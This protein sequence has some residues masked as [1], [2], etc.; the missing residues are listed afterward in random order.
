MPGSDGPRV[1]S[2]QQRIKASA[3]HSNMRTYHG[4]V[5]EYPQKVLGIFSCQLGQSTT[6]VDESN[7]CFGVSCHRHGK[8]PALVNRCE[9]RSWLG[10]A[11]PFERIA[12][13]TGGSHF[14]RERGERFHNDYV[15]LI[16]FGN[17]GC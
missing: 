3:Q 10:T 2:V 5:L 14:G 6:V 4:Q 13:F 15:Y 1:L 11:P 8:A 9:H 12:R 7:F 17:K 16:G